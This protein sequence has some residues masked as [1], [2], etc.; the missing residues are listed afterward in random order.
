MTRDGALTA[1]PYTFAR[2]PRVSS[3][4]IATL[5]AGYALFASSVQSFLSSRL[6]QPVEAT[7]STL[8][9]ETGADYVASLA[10]PC[11][12]FV[13]ETN[14]RGAAQGIV[15]MTTPFSYHLVD[16]L[17]GGSGESIELPRALTVLEQTVV[18]GVA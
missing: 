13:V 4:N 1:V 3:E 16:R 5:D 12:A 2:P 15:E 10:S 11:A 7:V 8:C 9:E 18:R 14:D 17:F 6:R